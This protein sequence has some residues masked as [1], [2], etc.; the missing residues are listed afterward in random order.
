MKSTE[1]LP[2]RY[3]SRERL[4]TMLEHEYGLLHERLSEQRGDKTTFFA[5]D[6][7]VAAKAYRDNNECHGWMGITFQPKPGAP[8]STVI[9]HM[10]MWDKDNVLQQQALGIVGVNLIYGGF[11]YPSDPARL[12]PSLTDNVG[13]SR[14]EVDMIKFDGP[15]IPGCRQSFNVP[16]YRAVRPNQCRD[17]WS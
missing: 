7:T 10:R 17:V 2:P 8:P 15:A 13:N 12:I 5:F 11:N 3:V 9:I 16:A 14:I 1:K 6:D 4:V